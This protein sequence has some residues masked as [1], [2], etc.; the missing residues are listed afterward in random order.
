MERESETYFLC[1]KWHRFYVRVMSSS[2]LFGANG[3]GRKLLQGK[4]AFKIALTDTKMMTIWIFLQFRSLVAG[5]GGNQEVFQRKFRHENERK[6]T[7]YTF[8]T[9]FLSYSQLVV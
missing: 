3:R 5:R 4:E 6:R 2:C 1:G 8:F 9:T 7:I